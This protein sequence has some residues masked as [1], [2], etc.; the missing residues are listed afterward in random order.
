MIIEKYHPGRA[1]EWDDFVERSK[2]GTFLHRRGFMD[3][4][5]H[6]FV[7]HSLMF[8][9][10]GELIALLPA[11][12]SGTTL[13]SHGG[14]TYGGLL[15]NERM[16]ATTALTLFEVL[17]DHL[18]S[19]G[20]TQLLYSP[21]PHIYHRLPAEEDLYA[22][23]RLGATTSRL[24]IS[25]ALTPSAHFPF[26]ELR[27]RGIKKALKAGVEIST[28]SSLDQFWPILEQ[29]LLQTHGVAPVHTQAE[30]EML[31]HRFPQNIRLHTAT[32]AGECLAGVVMFITPQVAHA[33]YISASNE[34]KTAGALDLLF[35]HLIDTA[36]A[37]S[38][39]FDFGK[40]TEQGGQHLNETL[41]FQKEGFAARA[42]CYPTLL[43]RL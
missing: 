35:A 7:D 20:F 38:P 33:Q 37:S 3:Y 5:A 13:H 4:H 40:S 11:N 27:R 21:T 31:M 2:N 28:H 24:E 12:A 30:M 17:V 14:L 22:L 19:L 8:T 39:Y 25:S 6:R 10:Q 18:R 41:I 16:T 1:Q 23:W 32:R 26:R 29:N 9:H 42:I 34:G 43:L 36:Y 15:T